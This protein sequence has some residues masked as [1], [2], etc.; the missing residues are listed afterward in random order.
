MCPTAIRRA[1]TAITLATLPRSSPH[2]AVKKSEF[3]PFAAPRLQSLSVPPHGTENLMMTTAAGCSRAHRVFPAAASAGNHCNDGPEHSSC[4]PS[5]SSPSPV[6][7]VHDCSVSPQPRSPTAVT[8]R[9]TSG[10]LLVSCARVFASIVTATFA[11]IHLVMT[12]H[13]SP[14]KAH[15]LCVGQLNP[16]E[17]GALSPA[18]SL[19]RFVVP[20]C[21]AT[22]HCTRS[23]TLV[24]V[25]DMRRIVYCTEGHVHL[26]CRTAQS[27]R[28]ML[29]SNPNPHY[30]F[31]VHL[32]RCV[33][34]ELNLGCV[35]NS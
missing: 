5:P 3:C 4:R 12:C 26:P 28:V 27:C 1:Y 30:H 16:C 6:G 23:I 7:P 17:T 22:T 21:S 14:V 18:P 31:D 20:H 8:A 24:K 25:A 2:T 32:T 29:T 33:H 15:I 34:I 9:F 19:A 11:S 13:P 35:E 10:F